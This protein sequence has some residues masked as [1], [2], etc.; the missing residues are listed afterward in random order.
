MVRE[1]DD[2]YVKP[3]AST[4]TSPSPPPSA[5]AGHVRRAAS[6]SS[7]SSIPSSNAGS[8][9]SYTSNSR[10]ISSSQSTN[11]RSTKSTQ[12]L[13]GSNSAPVPSPIFSK[14]R[15]SAAP[16]PILVTRENGHAN[17][18]NGRL[19]SAGGNQD[20]I[21][22]EGEE[23]NGEARDVFLPMSPSS[24]LPYTVN[25]NSKGSTPVTPSFTPRSGVDHA[26]KHSRI[27]ERNLSAFFPRPGQEGAGYGDTFGE[28]NHVHEVYDNHTLAP[29]SSKVEETTSKNRRGHHHRHSLSHN[30]S[31]SLDPSRLPSDLYPLKSPNISSPSSMTAPINSASTNYLP[32][33]TYSQNNKYSRL[34]STLRFLLLTL[35][36]PFGTKAAI[37][38]SCAQII[39]GAT[40]WIAGQNGESLSTTGLGYLVVFDGMGGLSRVFVEGSAGIEVFWNSMSGGKTDRSVRLPF[41]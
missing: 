38:L 18:R 28:S 23:E 12:P 31:T 20:Q 36:L 26:R 2:V 9:V 33:P 6:I 1:F 24:A 25:Y 14:R 37:T 17:G 7:F 3:A 21:M 4:S 16:A 11:I 22:E 27:H 32:V 30:F 35:S 34:P 10:S 8:S 19:P 15:I 41:G 29:T 39:L 5:P 40:L 13:A